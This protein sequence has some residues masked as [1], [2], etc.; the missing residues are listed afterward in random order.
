MGAGDIIGAS[1]IS[2]ERREEQAAAEVF[3]RV[4]VELVVERQTIEV[5]R[6]A[7]DGR[8]DVEDDFMCET[9]EVE[10]CVADCG[11]GV[12]E[13]N[14]GSDAGLAHARW[15]GSPLMSSPQWPSSPRP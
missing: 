2:A 9:I 12:P 10:D 13:R 5:L 1:Q 6:G 4:V 15:K 8:L 14:A 7:G 11:V 3:D